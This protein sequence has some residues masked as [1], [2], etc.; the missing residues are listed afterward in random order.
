MKK[1]SL[2]VDQLDN[3]GVLEIFKLTLLKISQRVP[4]FRYKAPKV[5]VTS[6]PTSLPFKDI[7]SK[8]DEFR[9]E[10]KKFLESI[11]K[12][13]IR[14]KIYKHHIVGRLDAAQAIV[15][16]REHFQHHMPQIRTLLNAIHR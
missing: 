7:V 2:G 12:Q 15:F 5:L 9:G 6:T 3:A 1:K 10:L 8:W 14:K 11:P 4:V 16:L 13:H